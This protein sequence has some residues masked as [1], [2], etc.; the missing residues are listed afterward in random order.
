MAQRTFIAYSSADPFVAD[1]IV[2][3]AAMARTAEIEYEP[4]SR[5]DVSG[6]PIDQSVFSW[7]EQADSFVADVSEPNHNVTYEVGLAIGLAKPTRLI[8]AANKD[9]KALE[10]IGL[11]HNIGHD[12]YSS[13]AGLVEVLKRRPTVAPWPVAKK[14]REQSVYFIQPS[15]V[16]DVSSRLLSG[17][18]RLFEKGLNA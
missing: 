11:L 16:D 14:N 2:N 1:T 18:K 4:W 15:T 8:R 10:A 6:Q 13:G 7:V 12:D 5:N 17:I 3:A 9:R